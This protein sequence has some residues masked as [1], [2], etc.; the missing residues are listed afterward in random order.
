MTTISLNKYNI[1]PDLMCMR[2][3]L[4]FHVCG[5]EISFQEVSESKEET[6]HFKISSELH[7]WIILRG[8]RLKCNTAFLDW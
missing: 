3:V 8:F 7:T 5:S 6:I 4:L 2:L 1:R